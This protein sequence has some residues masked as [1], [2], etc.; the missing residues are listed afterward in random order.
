MPDNELLPP[1]S[2]TQEKP[3]ASELAQAITETADLNYLMKAAAF[4]HLQRV[5]N[6]FAESSI[7]PERFRGNM[8]DCAIVLAMAWR[9]KADPMMFFNGVY[10]VH[11]RPGME[12]KL[13]IAL[14]NSQRVFEGPIQFKFEGSAMERKCTAF[15]THR[16]SGQLCEASVSM[17]MAKQEGW[18]KNTKWASM[19]DVMLR[20]RAAIFL[21]R[22]YCPEA[23]F[24][25][26]TS[27]ELAEIN[28]TAV[29]VEVLNEQ[30][31]KIEA[32][33][34]TVTQKQLPEVA[35]EPVD[36]KP[37]TE[38][39][40]DAQKVD[41]APPA[42]PPEKTADQ[43]REERKSLVALY[44]DLCETAGEQPQE[45]TKLSTPKLKQECDR[46]SE[47]IEEGR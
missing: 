42:Q 27:D 9:H 44:I 38:T 34:A 21:I 18:T 13:A 30:K 46:L 37:L 7:V 1:E 12:A 43:R 5:A 28:A 31:K 45:I 39:I 40:A 6:M 33:V 32:Q 16:T 35:A 14:V 8:A 11:G 36:E 3:S 10:V 47:A 15:A 22:F 24:G 25:M 4:E 29:N 23:M 19:P 41:D 20:Y 2:E 26:Q 17:D